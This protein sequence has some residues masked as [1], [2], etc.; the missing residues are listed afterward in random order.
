MKYEK[1]INE[2]K[3]NQKVYFTWRGW[4][5]YLRRA[6]PSNYHLVTSEEAVTN[7]IERLPSICEIRVFN[8]D[9]YPYPCVEVNL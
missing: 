5:I 4:D 3:K 6:T 8:D 1:E 9:N 7:I 2:I